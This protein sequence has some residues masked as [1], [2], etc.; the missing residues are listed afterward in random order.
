MGAVRILV[1]DDEANARLALQE[2]LE[3][4][5]YE[6][7][8]ATGRLEDLQAAAGFRPQ[9]ALIDVKARRALAALDPRPILVLMSTR[10]LPLSDAETLFVRKPLNLAE[11]FATIATAVKRGGA[12]GEPGG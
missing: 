2:L 10:D 8:T 6:V 11:L 5:G 1:V 12:L 4:E 9:V 7:M 3:E